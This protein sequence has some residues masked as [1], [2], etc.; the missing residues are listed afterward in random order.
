MYVFGLGSYSTITTRLVPD[1]KKKTR[2]VPNRHGD[3]VAHKRYAQEVR[4]WRTKEDDK[5]QDQK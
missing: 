5:I 3:E 4:K 2:L 1:L